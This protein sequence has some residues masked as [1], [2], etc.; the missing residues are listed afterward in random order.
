MSIEKLNTPENLDKVTPK[1]NTDRLSSFSLKE[2]VKTTFEGNVI[3]PKNGGEWTGE[4]GNSEW[5]PDPDYV[6]PSKSP[7]VER[8]RNNPDNLSWSDILDKHGMDSV[9]FKDGYPDLSQVAKESIQIDDFGIAR[10]ENFDQADEKTA[11][12]WDE[13]KK[14]G[15]TWTADDVAKWRKENNYTWHECEDCCTLQLVPTEIHNNI[16]HSGGISLKKAELNNN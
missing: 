11:K 6:P 10:D 1:N 16:P 13:E 12:K 9:P 15:K 5:K 7:N 8:P 3:L 14:D 4:P 2:E